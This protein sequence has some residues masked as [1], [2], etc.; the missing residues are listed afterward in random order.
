M[1]KVQKTYPSVAHAK[2]LLNY[3]LILVPKYRKKPFTGDIKETLANVFYEIADIC[4]FKI[5]SLAIEP[6]HVH[7]LIKCKPTHCIATLV[8]QIKSISAK[9]LWKEHADYLKKLYYKKKKVLWTSGYFVS[10]I[11]NASEDTVRQY[12]EN[13]G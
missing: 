9:R 8:N 10:S 5:D 2:Y 12:I 13:Q 11:G 4:N 3:H 1:S 6:D 7:L